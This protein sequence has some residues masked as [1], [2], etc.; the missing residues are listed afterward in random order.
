MSAKKVIIFDFDGTLADS[1]PIIRAIYT[2][3]AIKNKLTVLTDENYQ[4]LR[5]GSLR[6]ARKWSGVRFW[7]LPLLLRSMRR[8]MKL[9][10]EKVQLFPGVVKMIQDL[11]ETD[12]ELYILSRNTADTIIHVLERYDLQDNLQ[13]LDRRR[14]SF[15]SKASVIRMLLRSKRYKPETVWMIG[16][17]VRDIRAANQAGVNS[18]AVTWGFQDTSILE[19]YRP[20]KIVNNVSQLHK[21]L[22]GGD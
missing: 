9:E 21:M 22:R 18:I 13:I 8:L 14:R 7:Q 4:L 15:G 20:T 11:S 1:A 17:E 5:Q 6:D 3:I 19:R 2:E 16:D 12:H 10:S